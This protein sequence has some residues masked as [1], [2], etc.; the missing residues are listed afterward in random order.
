MVPTQLV[1][2]LSLIDPKPMRNQFASEH[3]KI[4]LFVGRLVNEKGV[5]VLLD[6]AP[7][8]LQ[9]Y[10]GTQ[11]LV[12]GTGYFMDELQNKASHLGI[13]HNVH[14]L[15]YVGD[16]ELLQLYKVADIVAIPSL[17]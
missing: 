12:V 10:P 6:A 4:V 16:T 17:L 15:G 14:F 9:N 13:S 2:I 5:Q 7:T 1:L 8:I 3:Q 11:F